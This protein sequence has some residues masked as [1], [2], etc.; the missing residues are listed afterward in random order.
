MD[1]TA[2][3]SGAAARR[4][5]TPATA[6]IFP[7]RYLSL[8]S[9]R[10]DGTAV[11]T[12]VWFVQDGG[13]LLIQ[14]GADSGKV[15]RI[16]RHPPVT[17]AVCSATGRLKGAPVAAQAWLLPDDETAR[18]ERLLAHKYRFDLLIIKPLRRLQMAL[19]PARAAEKQVAIA[20]R[21]G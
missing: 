18:V 5:S 3:G 10:R 9:Y 15:K 1:A 19:H 17:V 20:I 13:L 12:P 6:T 11:A 8:T 4:A 14:T 16:R 7:G 2:T 21:P